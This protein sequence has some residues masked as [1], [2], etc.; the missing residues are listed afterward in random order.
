MA[1]NKSNWTQDED[2]LLKMVYGHD[3]M[4]N[5]AEE[6]NRTPS[7]IK[8]R[9]YRIGLKIPSENRKNFLKLDERDDRWTKDEDNY[10]LISY[11][12]V[13]MAEILTTLGRSKSAVMM[14]THRLGVYKRK[15]GKGYARTLKH[16]QGQIDTILKLY[17]T[18][19]AKQLSN[20][21]G[22]AT[23]TIYKI[24]EYNNVSKSRLKKTKAIF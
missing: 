24:A 17:K 20:L 15:E 18:H 2:E 21:T 4:E 8:T 7:A 6:F 16:P 10:L 14:R 9:A 11:G 22:I 1:R 3:T 23:G 5:L 19:T 13:E 12:R